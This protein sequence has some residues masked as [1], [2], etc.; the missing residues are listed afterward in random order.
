MRVQWDKTSICFVGETATKYSHYLLKSYEL[1]ERGWSNAQSF[2]SILGFHGRSIFEITYDKKEET[3]AIVRVAWGKT[4][5]LTE[6]VHK[7]SSDTYFEP[8]RSFLWSLLI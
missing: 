7:T 5:P 6:N 3:G 8:E 4:D 2:A 1:H